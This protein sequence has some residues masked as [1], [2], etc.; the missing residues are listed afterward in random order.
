MLLITYRNVSTCHH[1]EHYMIVPFFLRLASFQAIAGDLTT[2]FL[3]LGTCFFDWILPRSLRPSR[4][5]DVR[6]GR[7]GI[8]R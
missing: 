4:Q 6:R 8:L 7:I 3:L 2:A 5:I 1:N